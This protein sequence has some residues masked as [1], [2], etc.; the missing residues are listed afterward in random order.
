M[1]PDP[2]APG[3]RWRIRLDD[4]PTGRTGPRRT[5]VERRAEPD[6]R[7]GLLQ[8][9]AGSTDVTLGGRVR[10]RVDTFGVTMTEQDQNGVQTTRI[11]PRWLVKTT[12]FLVVALALGAWFALDAM[13][14]YPKRGHADADVKL[15]A[16]LQ[17]AQ[18]STQ[19][20][21]ASVPEPKTTLEALRTKGES[22]MSPVERA[23][24]AWLTS[25]SRVESLSRI[26]AENAANPGAA[27]PTVFPE[28]R[29]TLDE[30]DTALAG[31]PQPKPLSAFDIPS[32]YAMLALCA[33]VV[34]W[35][36]V[37]MARVLSTKYRYQPAT[38]TLTLPGGGN[39][40]AADLELLDKRKW[41]KYYAFLKVT[42]RP[43]ELKL[44][45]YRYIP[46]EEWILDMWRR[47][48]HYDPSADEQ[49]GQASGGG[50]DLGDANV[51]SSADLPA[52]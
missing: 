52:M 19:L 9:D 3:R 39:V 33:A 4:G 48:P 34:V 45:L 38:A 24:F 21:T 16:Y 44:D 31:K 47:S 28:P 6:G 51:M 23:R 7:H 32:Q 30:L 36:L 42:G 18:N 40:A 13:V 27:S 15:L 20:F 41:D 25:L 37:M 22:A 35:L 17:Q 1:A 8:R 26:Q 46:L 49:D 50:D 5:L 14:I 11:N 43:G 29:R 12:I 2:D 10:E